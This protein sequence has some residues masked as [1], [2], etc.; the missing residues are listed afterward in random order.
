[1]EPV[2]KFEPEP[3]A[4][5]QEKAEAPAPLVVRDIHL[6]LAAVRVKDD[7]EALVETLRKKGYAVQL[8]SQ[9]R[10]GWQRVIVGPFLSERAAQELRLQLRA[11]RGRARA[12]N[13]PS[14]IPCR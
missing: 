8:N 13:G 9:T 1:M 7:A 3:K 10:D 2:V 12:V 4:G 5:T 11:A 14:P 6:P